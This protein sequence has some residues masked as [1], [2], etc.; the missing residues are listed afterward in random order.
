MLKPQLSPE[1]CGLNGVGNFLEW[2][3]R[4]CMWVGGRGGKGEEGEIWKM[5]LLMKQSHADVN[6]LFGSR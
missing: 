2:C 4:S 1:H 3:V 6:D 5:E